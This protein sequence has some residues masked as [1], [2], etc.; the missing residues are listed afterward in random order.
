MSEPETAP[1]DPR[2]EIVEHLRPMRAFAMSLTRNSAAADDLVQDA[3]MKAWQNIEKFEA[4]TNMRAW[5]FTILRNTFYSNRRKA[6]RE[7][8]DVDGAMAATLSEKPAHDGRLAMKDFEKAFAQLPDEQREALILVGASGF[9]YEEAAITCGVAVG[10][11]KSRVNR[12]R[13]TLC[14]M[15]DLKDDETMEMTDRATMAVVFEMT[16]PQRFSS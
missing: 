10:T 1:R 13:N 5:L 8:A 3:I 12:G 6:K 15:L 14:E 9:T 11:I 16:P 7:V 2:E 4:G